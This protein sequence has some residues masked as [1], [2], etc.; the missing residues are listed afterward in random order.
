MF[1]LLAL[2]SI[3]SL[4]TTVCTVS[5]LELTLALIGVWIIW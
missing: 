3:V 4:T 1:E 5:P 2:A